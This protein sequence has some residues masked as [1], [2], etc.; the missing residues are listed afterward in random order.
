M[1]TKLDQATQEAATVVIVANQD[2]DK[3]P[4]LSRKAVKEDANLRN[5]LDVI[6]NIS[7]TRYKVRVIKADP[8]QK[9]MLF[10]D[11]KIVELEKYLGLTEED[12]EGLDSETKINI[13]LSNRDYSDSILKQFILVA[14]E[15]NPEEYIPVTE[16]I[17]LTEIDDVLYQALLQAYYTVNPDQQESEEET[18]LDRFPESDNERQEVGN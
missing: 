12:Y 14:N 11:S 7:E 6:I 8:F 9:L 10:R 4:F 15:D 16:A 3:T 1:S 18:E 17:P 5:Y 2:S 13:A